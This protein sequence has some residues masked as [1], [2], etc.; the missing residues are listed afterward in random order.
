MRLPGHHVYAH[1]RNASEI[2]EYLG[3]KEPA[4][5]PLDLAALCK[6]K[7][8]LQAD[9]LLDMK[10]CKLHQLIVPAQYDRQRLNNEE[11]DDENIRDGLREGSAATS[12]RI[13]ARPTTVAISRCA[14]LQTSVCP[15]FFTSVSSGMSSTTL[16]SL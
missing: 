5:R 6:K 13:R 8:K 2:L 11:L 9:T 10:C 14:R 3:L 7:P 12:P 1:M 16:L 15:C 4:R